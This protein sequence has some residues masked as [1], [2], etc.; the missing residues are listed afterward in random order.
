MSWGQIVVQLGPLHRGVA[1]LP[2]V[3][4]PQPAPPGNHQGTKGPVF[5]YTIKKN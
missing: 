5:G 1:P 3:Q 2:G 4:A